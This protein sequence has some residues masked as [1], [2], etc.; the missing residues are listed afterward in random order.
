[1]FF[2]FGF[3]IIV[4]LMKLA[5]V[6]CMHGIFIKR[7]ADVGRD[8]RYPA[9]PDV[10]SPPGPAVA[11]SEFTGLCISGMQSMRASQAHRK[12]VRELPAIQWHF[13][14]RLRSLVMYSHMDLFTW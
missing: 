7:K 13:Y 5:A 12:Q 9:V 2:F 3:G 6:L 10:R 14:G 11:R 4:L 8:A 1:M